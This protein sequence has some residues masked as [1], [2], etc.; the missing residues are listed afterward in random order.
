[1]RPFQSVR[2]AG[3]EKFQSKSVTV[4]ATD[5]LGASIQQSIEIS[6]LDEIKGTSG[7]D[8]HWGSGASDRLAATAFHDEIAAIAQ[9]GRVL[10]LLDACRSGGA[11]AS[12][13]RSLRAMLTAPNVTVLTSSTAG[14]ASVEH[15]DWEN[16]AFTEALLEALREADYDGD[17][18]IRISDLSRYLA[19]RVPALTSGRQHPDVEII[20]QDIRILAAA[21]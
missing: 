9:H 10:V 21:L 4:K 11:I 15:A 20:G 7:K 3:Y 16:G 12:A 18:L 8:R 5:T 13:D 1:M 19:E 17:A 6:I 14:E 2:G